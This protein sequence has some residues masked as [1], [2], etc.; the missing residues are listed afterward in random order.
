MDRI[1]CGHVKWIF[2][3]AERTKEGFWGRSYLATGAVKDRHVFQ[4]DQQCYPLLEL[5]EYLESSS[6]SPP[7]AKTWGRVVDDVL[8]FLLKRKAPEKWVFQ[9]NETPGDD[10]VSMLYSFSSNVLLWYTLRKMVP[11]THILGLTSPI[12]GWISSIHHDTLEA[13]TTVYQDQPIFA[14]LCDLEGSFEIYYDANDIPSV[15]APLWGF[16][17][18]DDLR[19]INLFKFAFSTEN[20]RAY[21]ANGEYGG[22]GSIHTPGPWPLGDAQEMLLAR[23]LEDEERWHRAKEKAFKKMQWDGGFAEANDEITGEVISKHWFSWPG[24][25]IGAALIEWEYR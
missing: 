14:Y 19:W 24:C 23:T 20:K 9:T 6:L 16:C 1:L 4:L 22:L 3:R 2:D 15:L 17:S 8:R 18:S 13:F 5:A 21:F 7:Q 12:S 25:M 10:P 11:H